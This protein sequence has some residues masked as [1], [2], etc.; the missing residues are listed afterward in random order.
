LRPPAQV[1]GTS[2]LIPLGRY[3]PPPRTTRP[4]SARSRENRLQRVLFLTSPQPVVGR[5]SARAEVAPRRREEELLCL[6][7]PASNV[8][9]V[10]HMRWHHLAHCLA[11]LSSPGRVGRSAARTRKISGACSVSAI[12]RDPASHI[13]FSIFLFLVRSI[14]RNRFGL[15]MQGHRKRGL[16]QEVSR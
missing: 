4:K 13:E 2:P 8:L 11:A 6:L 15:D 16:R 12:S 3:L 9:A 5:A 14:F 10:V 7:R 1:I